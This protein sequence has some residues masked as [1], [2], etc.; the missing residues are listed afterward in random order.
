MLVEIIIAIV[1]GIIAGT[2]TGLIPGIHINLISTILV[3]LSAVLLT[4]TSPLS[5]AVF[6]ISM[7]V[8]HT[9]LDSIPSIYL[10]APDADMALGVLPGHKM[11]LSGQGYSAVYLTVIGSFGGLLLAV[12][13]FPYLIKVVRF[14]YPFVKDYI[15]YFLILI[16][17]IMILREKL[18]LWAL[19][20]FVL[21]GVLGL[22]IFSIPNLNNPL[23]GMLSG[24]FGVSALV[25]SFS[26]K[27]KI[28]KQYI[29]R[30]RLEKSVIAQSLSAS[31]F[32]GTLTSFLPGLGPAQGA[33]IAQGLTR[34]IG[35]KGFMVLIGG[36][37]TV[38]MVL[39]LVTLFTLD[40]AR[41]G[42]VIA[43]SSLMDAKLNDI[44]VLIFVSLIV[45]FICV[46]LALFI[47]KQ[48]SK[49][50]SK[51]NYKKLVISI[52]VLITLFS[53]ILSGAIGL[54][55]LITSTFIGMIAPLVGISRSHAMGCLML[56]VILFLL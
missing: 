33:V 22:I 47:S 34:N 3:S 44:L 32:A 35:D 23:F 55:I 16:V 9:F 48:F 30:P 39:S 20:L 13:L 12:L 17:I 8:T 43:I 42:S 53:L 5:L 51:L 37:N 11:L 2:I 45:G 26:Q 21:S 27:V 38:N 1:I 54:V 28:P 56:P 40:K 6:I 25:I 7:S 46:F 4:Y 29:K 41:N 36:I 50:I 15:A 14:I 18:K 24:L 31:T 19:F 10:G 52:I 49:I